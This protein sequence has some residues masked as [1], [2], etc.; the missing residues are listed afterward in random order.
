M[1]MRQNALLCHLYYR[2]KRF[3]RFI[4]SIR[5]SLCDVAGET[6]KEGLS[7]ELQCPNAHLLYAS[8]T[9]GSIFED[10]AGECIVHLSM[11]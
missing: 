11:F 6:K 8:F 4:Q 9:C 5:V 1:Y 3:I 10:V 2:K 7:C